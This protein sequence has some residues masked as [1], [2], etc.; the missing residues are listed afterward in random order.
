MTIKKINLT[1]SKVPNFIGAWDIDHS[2]CT[3]FN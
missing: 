2:V 3:D 1:E